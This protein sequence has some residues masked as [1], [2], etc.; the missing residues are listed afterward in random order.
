LPSGQAACSFQ[1]T[2]FG[3]RID[4][5]TRLSRK[6]AAVPGSHGLSLRYWRAS[7]RSGC[8]PSSRLSRKKSAPLRQAQAGRQRRSPPKPRK[9]PN[10]A[11][12]VPVPWLQFNATEKKRRLETTGIRL[13]SHGPG[14]STLRFPDS[15]CTIVGDANKLIVLT[16]PA[17]H[18]HLAVSQDGCVCPL[19][20]THS[21]TKEAG[22]KYGLERNKMTTARRIFGWGSADFAS[23]RLRKRGL[24]SRRPT[25]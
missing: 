25:R 5:P 17:L 1:G 15:K 6:S 7:S 2:A 13:E 4:E 14:S 16:R 22:K 23:G 18:E 8:P 12:I 19:P 20:P 3:L 10:S 9:S 21:K 11:L 24:H